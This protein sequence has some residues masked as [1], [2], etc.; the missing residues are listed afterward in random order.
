MHLSGHHRDTLLLIFQRPANQNVEWHDVLSFLEA[1]GSVE[2]QRDDMFLFRLGADTQVFTRPMDKG[3]DVQQP[4]DLRRMLSSA[5]Y[6]NVVAEL[7]AK[8]KEV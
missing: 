2:Q 3:I 8:G 7:E 6:A 5:G 4:A 1:V